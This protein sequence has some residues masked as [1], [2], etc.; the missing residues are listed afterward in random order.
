MRQLIIINEKNVI[1]APGQGKITSFNF[2][3]K[4]YEEKAFP[5]LLPKG[6]FGYNT[7]R[8]IPISPAWYFNQPLLNFNQYFTSDAD[9]L[10][11][12]QVFV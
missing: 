5:Y 1:I 4:F 3:K 10:F 11:F 12:C 7:P 2:S 6:K 9:Y 8:D